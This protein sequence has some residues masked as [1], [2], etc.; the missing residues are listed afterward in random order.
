[1]VT[2]YGKVG[3]VYLH[4]CRAEMLADKTMQQAA[5]SKHPMWALLSKY[6]YMF[7]YIAGCR[8]ARMDSRAASAPLQV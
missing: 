3:S 6:L 5:A 4:F 7:V 2:G 1:M 8:V